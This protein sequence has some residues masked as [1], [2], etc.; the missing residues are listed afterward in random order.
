[1][2]NKVLN[3]LLCMALPLLT[4]CHSTNI[5]HITK[6]EELSSKIG[7]DRVNVL[8]NDS[9]WLALV[10]I[11]VAYCL[12]RGIYVLE[13]RK[14]NGLWKFLERNLT[15][16]FVIV[17]VMG[18][19]VYSTGM[20]IVDE[21][22][23]DYNKLL[24]VM[25][26]SIIHAFGMFLL[27][28]DISAVHDA[29]HDNLHYMTWFS[30]SHFAA[31][32]VSMMFVIKH[33]GYN[34]VAGIQLWLTSHGFTKKDT[35]YVFWGMNDASYNLAKDIKTHAPKSH[36]MLFVKTADNEDE[37]TDRSGIDRLFNFLSVKNKELE[38]FKDLGT[39]STNAF[40]RLSK[41]EITNSE[42]ASGELRILKNRLGLYSLIK[43]LDRTTQHVHIL[44]LGEDETSNIKAAANLLHDSDLN[45]FAQHKKV[46]IH[47]HARYDSMNGVFE[48]IRYADNL[49]V[50]IIDSAHLAIET[51]KC[52]D[53]KLCLPVEYVDVNKDATVTDTFRGMVIGMGQCGRDAL[54][55]MYEYGAF[56]NSV[57]DD[58]G[59][60]SRSPFHVDVFDKDMKNIGSIFKLSRPAVSASDILEVPQQEPSDEEY[61]VPLVHLYHSD[62]N[63]KLFWN[64]VCEIIN[65]VN[66]IFITI[67]DD[68]AG[69]TLAVR[70]L[71][72]AMKKHA[73]IERLRIFVRSYKK[74]LLPHME[75]IADHY[76]S[77]V[78][79][80]LN[81]KDNL[82]PIYIFGKAQDLY[83]WHNIIDD[84]MQKESIRYYNSYEGITE[85]EKEL[86]TAWN[87][88]RAKKLGVRPYGFGNIN[89][90][91]R[92][93]FQDMENAWHRKTKIAIIEKSLGENAELS[94]FAREVTS[95][96]RN[97]D[98]SY[99]IDTAWETI[100]TTL[101]QMEH[102]RWNA[103]HE[104][105]GYEYEP[106]VKKEE[107]DIKMQHNCLTSW[108]KLDG[109]ETRG[110]DYKVIETSL[111]MYLEE[112]R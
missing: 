3:A 88:R 70:L 90:V 5:Y 62:F 10:C 101:A 74:E 17:W 72:L 41:C 83:T 37:I 96:T 13:K 26:M 81:L 79:K 32:M 52:S 103:S 44:M 67:K 6:V 29:F 65:K 33:F 4:S 22:Q 19:C 71:K 45:A 100:M 63:D 105:L 43:L 82:H 16:L 48:N 28:S 91:R 47:C 34:I 64:R 25:T 68:D 49:R 50:R 1:M 109:D 2:K 107:R 110:Y 57:K 66:C 89:E 24:S 69:M 31:A 86:G 18:F 108:N 76:N 102:L 77:S 60:I 92:M 14:W 56:V 36:R 39:L 40:Y 23:T 80:S 98:N 106:S 59:D 21:P 95:H 35:L 55:F 87:A 53:E 7:D 104:M 51:L 73:D 9:F 75:T 85:S 99:G 54:R 11:L 46:T 15:I 38:E 97:T 61:H 8:F 12:A 84:S 20:F 30:L 58:S 27:E 78:V 112:S 111:K 93:E 42:I 94:D